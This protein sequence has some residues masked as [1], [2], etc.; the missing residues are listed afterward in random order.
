MQPP[1]DHAA[2]AQR[3]SRFLIGIAVGLGC[4][5]VLCLIVAG[6]A[7]LLAGIWTLQGTLGPAEGSFVPAALAL[8]C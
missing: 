7:T 1:I 8:L 2:A 3:E 4:L 6:V 5:L